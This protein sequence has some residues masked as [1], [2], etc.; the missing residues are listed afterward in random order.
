M[1][2]PTVTTLPDAA[3]VAHE[4]AAQT[5]TLAQEAV[6][7]RGRFVIC[8]SGGST[9]KALHDRLVS[10][11]FLHAMPW[12]ETWFVFGDERTVGPEDPESNYRMARETLFEPAGIPTERIL[13][14]EGEYEPGYAARDYEEKL[15]ELFEGGPPAVDLLLLG[16]GADG[17]TASLF[18]DTEAL[19]IT[20][21]WIAENWVPKLDTWRITWTFPALAAARHT[22]FLITGESKREALAAAFGDDA[23]ER[24]PAGQV[25]GDSVEVLTDLA[26]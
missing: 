10:D 4:A 25:R 12:D 23:H 22:L 17:H 15:R 6:D 18:P 1:K 20:D 14:I 26:V 21:R 2:A 8:L 9:P 11:P 5:L 24:P 19:H 13:R 3:S 16:M 7:A